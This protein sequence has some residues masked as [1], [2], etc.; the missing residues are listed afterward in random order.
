MSLLRSWPLIY[1]ASS[2]KT[3][4]SRSLIYSI[5]EI[6]VD[7]SLL[8]VTLKNI[9]T[10]YLYQWI[11]WCILCITF[12]VKHYFILIVGQFKSD[13]VLKKIIL[14]IYNWNIFFHFFF[15]DDVICKAYF[16]SLL[17]IFLLFAPFSSS[18]SSFA[19]VTFL[20]LKLRRLTNPK[21][22]R[23]QNHQNQNSLA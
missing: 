23:N 15:A 18:K 9:I 20:I 8:L 2:F 13:P 10:H 16:A 1:W 11:I 6:S 14:S 12:A 19:D 7:T 17:T 3:P 22:S 4:T 5:Y 21:L